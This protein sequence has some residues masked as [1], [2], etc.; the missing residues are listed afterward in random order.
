MNAY[1][2]PLDA[3][4][5]AVAVLVSG[6]VAMQIRWPATSARRIAFGTSHPLATLPL[7][8]GTYFIWHVPVIYDAALRHQHSL[9][10]LKH[11]TYFLAGLGLWWPVVH[12]RWSN[13]I[14]A[15]YLFPA[16][17]LVSPLG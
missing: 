9:L 14:K 4:A 15:L 5:L 6:Y 8:L 12:G 11:A 7:W 2:W 17:V 10:H 16:F 3:E 1:A 13:G